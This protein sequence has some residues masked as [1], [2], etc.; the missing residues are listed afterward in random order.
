M[1]TE[2]FLLCQHCTRAIESKDELAFVPKTLS[3]VYLHRDCY[4][5]WSSDKDP[6]WNYYKAYFSTEQARDIIRKNRKR[7]LI[8][9][10][11]FGLTL[12][13]LVLLFGMAAS[14]FALYA[15]PVVLISFLPLFRK[16]SV[17][18]ELQRIDSIYGA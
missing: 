14:L 8:S 17:K 15:L 12:I 7:F 10:V 1:S 18:D 13:I 3:F 9:I 4:P 11:I 16:R 2:S 5:E 6:F